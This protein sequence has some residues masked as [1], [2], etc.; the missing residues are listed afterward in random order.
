MLAKLGMENILCGH[1]DSCGARPQKIFNWCSI[2]FGLITEKKAMAVAMTLQ[3]RGEACKRRGEQWPLCALECV[4]E[5]RG[6]WEGGALSGWMPCWRQGRHE[7][8]YELF[9]ALCAW[10]HGQISQ[11]MSPNHSDQMSQRSLGSLCNVKIK[12]HSVSESVSDK[13]TYWAVLDS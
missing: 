6:D 8:G 10:G 9:G 5:L 7:F 13:V 1:F 4:G 11:V 12:S 3:W 2:V